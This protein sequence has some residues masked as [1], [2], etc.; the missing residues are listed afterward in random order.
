MRTKL[1]APVG[2]LFMALAVVA[3]GH[4]E[5]RVVDQY[6]NAVN[7]QDNQTLSSFSVVRFDKK[8]DRWSIVNVS[9]ETKSPATLPDLAKK[10]KD[11]DK[12]IADNKKQAAAFAQ[13]NVTA[14][15]QVSDIL[16]KNGKI[17]ANLQKIATE[18][19]KFNQN[20]RDLKKALA[21]AKEALD[22][23]RRNAQLSVGLT[24]LD[25]LPGEMTSTNVELDLTIGGKAQNYV[26]GL[27]KY[28]LQPSGQAGRV[29][30][31]WVVHTLEPKS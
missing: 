4:P 31:R 13:E 27:R 28:D 7:A 24:D 18:R 9:P 22:R 30:S 25:N 11:I 12:Q 6:F 10:A 26:M 15:N 5:K 23:E 19:E 3:C 20:D 21:E 29:M 1:L 8:V 14:W 16:G 17:P 2:A